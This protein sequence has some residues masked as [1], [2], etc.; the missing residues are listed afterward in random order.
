MIAFTGP[1]EPA[2]FTMCFKDQHS[3]PSTFALLSSALL[4]PKSTNYILWSPVLV[5][6]SNVAPSHK[7][8]LFVEI[9]PLSLCSFNVFFIN[10]FSFSHL[11]SLQSRLAFASKLPL[12]QKTLCW[13]FCVPGFQ[14]ASVLQKNHFAHKSHTQT[15]F[16]KQITPLSLR[17]K[18]LHF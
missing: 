17:Q 5:I 2:M 16:F 18:I 6:I 10:I 3:L 11:N 12:I 14:R 1:F 4:R 9:C 7:A 15:Q 13:L 8:K